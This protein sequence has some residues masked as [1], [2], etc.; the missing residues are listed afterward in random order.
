MTDQAHRYQLIAIGASAGGL[1]AVCQL[2]RNLPADFE[3]PIAVVQHRAKESEALAEI[4]QECTALRVVEV[5]DKQPL[6]GRTVYIAP[7]DYHLLIDEGVFA[8]ST[9][10]LVLYSRPSIDVFFDSAADAYGAGLIGVVLTGANSDGTKGLATI[11]S[12]GG[13]ALVQDPQTAEVKVMP[14]SAQQGVSRAR[15]L[16]LDQIANH[17]LQLERLQ[18]QQVARQA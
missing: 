5:E 4:L 11:V 10:G 16:D 15:V 12:R 18:R 9:E 2:I 7:P 13:K 14:L 3:I 6:E 1:N 8:L 17:L